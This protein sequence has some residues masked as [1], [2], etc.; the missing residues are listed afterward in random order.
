[1]NL[2]LKMFFL[3]ITYIQSKLMYYMWPQF[4]KSPIIVK[5]E[6]DSKHV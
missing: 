2:I 6:I 5:K 3:V 1:M 4:I